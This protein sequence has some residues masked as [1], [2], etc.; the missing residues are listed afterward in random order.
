MSRVIKW[1]ATGALVLSLLT[2][3]V[4]WRNLHG[5]EALQPDALAAV[6]ADPETA[7]R[8]ASSAVALG[9]YLAR[10]GNC[11]ACHTS[12]GGP[13]YAGGRAIAT[14][15]G[16]V[17]AGN[18]TPEANTGLGRW[19]AAEFRRALRHGR[20]RDG[21]LLYPAFPY[22]HF[23]QVTTA[24]ANALWA[25]L[26]S[27]PPVVQA[28]RPHALRWPY[29]SQA[30][31][32]VWRAL[33]FSPA[34]FV[35]DAQQD[36]DWNRGAYLV[37]GLGH[38]AACHA[39]R[40]LLGGSGGLADA[41]AGS[42]LTAQRWYAPSLAD[43]AEAGVSGWTSA[44]VVQLLKT[45][46]NRRASVMGPMAEVVAGSTQYLDEPDLRAMA[47][48][49]IALPAP[50]PAAPAWRGVRQTDSL[51]QGDKLYTRHCADCHGAQGQ[52]APGIY[53]ALAG[54]RAVTQANPRNLVLAI[55]RGGF[56]PA[57]DANP[58]P[59]GMPAFDLSHADLAALSTWL[60]AAWGHQAAPVSEVE[61]LLAR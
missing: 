57:T 30:A 26:R 27:L 7:A 55:T 21:H 22:P 36:A 13:A 47:R 20:S 4:A 1:L 12:P 10:A 52:G 58:R 38:C 50:L 51:A 41:G 3:A 37:N 56:A 16:S 15:F 33:Y 24:D 11:A 14:P 25:F 60:R 53:P 59:Y 39:S 6:T 35:P 48:Y 5:E 49:L 44:E 18:L 28:N 34:P 32:A 54:N 43:P 2:A 42:T 9:A 40:N 46:I 31:L 45:G 23:S 8:A 61:V 17:Y 19:S 29:N